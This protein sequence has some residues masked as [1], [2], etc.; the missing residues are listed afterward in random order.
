MAGALATL[1]M[2]PLDWLP[3]AVVGI[4]AF[5]WLWDTAPGPRS[6]LLRGW[7][8]GT[9]HFAVGSY[10]ILEAFFVPPADYAPLGP[11]IVVGLAALLVVLGV[12]SAAA[13]WVRW[14]LAERAIAAAKKAQPGWAG[15]EAVARRGLDGLIATCRR[16][17]GLWRLTT[18][19]DG[20]PLDDGVDLYDQ[21]FVLFA[22]AAAASAG[23]DPDAWLRAPSFDAAIA[24]PKA[25]DVL[26]KLEP[27][28]DISNEALLP[29]MDVA[30]LTY[31]LMLESVSLSFS[32]L[33]SKVKNWASNFSES[34]ASGRALI[35]V[36]L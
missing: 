11:P 26:K 36:R 14:A 2:P 6:A 27:N 9:G 21:A 7:A 32:A 4:V 30:A 25:R 28:F 15:T 8:W 3:L 24:G 29:R 17:D 13:A 20:T 33:S 22:L 10:W 12:V 18:D 23:I 1:A 5:V 34:A 16:D 35:W 31:D 19:A